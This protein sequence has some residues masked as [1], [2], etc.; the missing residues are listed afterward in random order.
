MIF[1]VLQPYLN[2]KAGWSVLLF[3]RI[4]SWHASSSLSFLSITKALLD[5]HF[6]F[7][8]KT[9]E[10]MKDAAARCRLFLWLHKTVSV[11]LLYLF[12][13]CCHFRNRTKKT[14]VSWLPQTSTGD[15]QMP[16]LPVKLCCMPKSWIPMYYELD[17]N[18]LLTI[19]E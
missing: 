19:A 1:C 4:T 9:K 14:G 5:L 6:L 17:S 18:S 7:E 12:K 2:A 16:C 8:L 3:W 10:M 13:V 15:R 11:L